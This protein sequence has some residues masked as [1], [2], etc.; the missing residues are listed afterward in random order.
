MNGKVFLDTNVL[1]YLFDS[2][3]PGKKERAAEILGAEGSRGDAVLSTQVL[4]EFYVSVTRKL[5]HPLADAEALEATERFAAFPVVSIDAPMVVRAIIL[6]QAA[7]LS[8]WDA[9]IVRSA[10]ESGCQSLYSEDLQDGWSVDGVTVENP[11]RRRP[12]PA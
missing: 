9:L 11:F 12:K 4:E 6:S 10:V 8:L 7:R 3:S 1:V 5:R 2:D